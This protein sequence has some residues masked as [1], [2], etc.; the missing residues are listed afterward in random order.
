MT[1]PHYSRA[2]HQQLV[3]AFHHQQQQNEMMEA[4]LLFLLFMN[5]DHIS[6]PAPH[7]RLR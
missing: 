4:T 5:F 2:N 7:L 1:C 6:A 3:P